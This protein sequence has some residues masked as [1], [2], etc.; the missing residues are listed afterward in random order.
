[1]SKK[2]HVGRPTNEELRIRRNKK[3]AMT[4]FPIALSIIAI[5]YI[6]INGVS[7]SMGNSVV[8]YY[9]EDPSYS[10]DGTNCK[11]TLKEKSIYL[12]DINQDGKITTE[13]YEL[14]SKYVELAFND[15]EDEMNLSDLQVKAADVDESGEV[16]AVDETIMRE[17]FDGT[18][19]TYGIYKENI[20]VKRLC[21]TGYELKGE[22][23]YKEDVVK[24][25][26]EEKKLDTPTKVDKKT[27][28]IHYNANGE[29]SFKGDYL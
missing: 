27:Y 13:D 2:N 14:L 16:Y 21:N 11:K 18:V 17:Y 22:F 23:C 19:S 1:M 28:T 3:I 24:A 12:G 6:T 25:L 15:S 7:Q 29:L 10:L 4:I 5:I 9:C 20:G 26:V 8:E